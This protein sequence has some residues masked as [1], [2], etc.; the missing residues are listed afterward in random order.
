MILT[1]DEIRLIM[2][3]ISE[4]YGRGYAEDKKVAS[5]QAKL[6]I[7]AEAKI[8]TAEAIAKAEGR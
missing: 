5:L 2:A 6:S 7:M 8:R 4:K 3:L 1:L